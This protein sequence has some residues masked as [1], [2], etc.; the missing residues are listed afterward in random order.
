MKTFVCNITLYD[1]SKQKSLYH[2]ASCID[3]ACFFPIRIQFTPIDNCKTW[4]QLYSFKTLEISVT[5][6][7]GNYFSEVKEYKFPVTFSPMLESAEV[8]LLDE[9]QA[10]SFLNN[11]AIHP[12]A[13]DSPSYFLATDPTK[14]KDRSFGSVFGKT[15]TFSCYSLE[16]HDLPYCNILKYRPYDMQTLPFNA[17]SMDSSHLFENFTVENIAYTENLYS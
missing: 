2:L 13:D 16:F 10:Q 14:F 4:E 9:T 12:T 5:C 1:K 8:G 15:S 17:F 3:Q 7:S 6:I 11:Y